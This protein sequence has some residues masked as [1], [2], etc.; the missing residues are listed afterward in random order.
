ME[1]KN[2]RKAFVLIA[3]VVIGFIIISNFEKASS[4]FSQTL[5][6]L[7]PFIIGLCFAFILNV[8]L[9]FFEKKVFKNSPQKLKRPISL[10]TTYFL[11]F[12]VILV[13]YLF[14]IPELKKSFSVL[15]ANLPDYISRLEAWIESLTERFNLSD[16]SLSKWEL[17]FENISQST[18]KNMPRVLG[19]TMD[20]VVAVVGGVTKFLIGFTL[21]IYMLLQKEKL[22]KNLKK[23]LFAFINYERAEHI[24][25]IGKLSNEIFS[26]FVFGQFTEVII[27]GILCFL[28]MTFFSM[29]YA[30]LISSI[31]SITAFI[32]FFGAFIGTAFGVIL[33]IMVKPITAFWFVIFIIILQQIEGNFIYPKVV[34]G[35]I[36]LPGIWV[37]SA[38]VL[39]GNLF[40]VVGMILGVPASAVLYTLL[41]RSV[42]KR[43]KE[44]GLSL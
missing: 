44:K 8:P 34:G 20:M 26:R 25:N 18:Q 10:I 40:G 36:G 32:P 23:M 38:V 11:I 29:P 19:G 27:I 6:L 1:F 17:F 22:C 37:L 39:G 35:S 12:G 3:F 7:S 14:V 9:N 13:I 4:L 33:L 16:F 2:T 30:L 24:I 43:L 21:S 5:T 42:L 41:K 28:G 15:F 31:I